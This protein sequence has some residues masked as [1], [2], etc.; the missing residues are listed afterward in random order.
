MPEYF[1]I[2]LTDNTRQNYIL[3]NNT[4][5]QWA[6][7]K[8]AQSPNEKDVRFF[9]KPEHA[10]E[11]IDAMKKGCIQGGWSIYGLFHQYKICRLKEEYIVNG[12]I[13]ATKLPRP[14]NMYDAYIVNYFTRRPEDGNYIEA[15]NDNDFEGRGSVTVT[16]DISKALRFFGRPEDILQKVKD[17]SGDLVFKLVGVDN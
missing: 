17:W 11:C 14:Q 2:L 6:D 3:V 16:G 7:F 15:L 1:F 12:E 4:D 10:G 8:I 9:R 5:R 13:D